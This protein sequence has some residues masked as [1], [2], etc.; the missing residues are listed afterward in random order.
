MVGYRLLDYDTDAMSRSGAARLGAAIASFALALLGAAWPASA[1]L[2]GDVSAQLGVMKRF[3]SE[4]PA[5]ANDD[6][7]FG[8]IGQLTGH[9]ALIPLVH[10]GAYLGHDI[11]PLSGDAAARDI[12]FAGARAKGFIPVTPASLR[13]WVF[14]GF[15][16]AGVYARSYQ[17]TFAVPNGLGGT[18]PTPVRVEGAGGGFFEV[19]FGLGAS[20]KFFSPW[21]LCAELG[22]RAG[23]GHQGS[24]YTG[25]GPQVTIPASGNP[26]AT[27]NASPSG[28]D[29]FAVG[30]TI[31]IQLDL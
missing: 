6:A 14:A 28:L 11:S 18:T 4:R 23:F 3:L 9:V 7:T 29:S 12:T 15:G 20:Y 25:N 8:P 16:Y 27:Q 31:G 5:G 30:L 13:T 19:P 2:H 26:N 22:F 17:T 24:V 21:E 1:Q 10:V